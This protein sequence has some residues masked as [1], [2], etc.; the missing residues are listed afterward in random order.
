M[1]GVNCDCLADKHDYRDGSVKG[2][3]LIDRQFNQDR[4]KEIVLD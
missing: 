2:S 4:L 1:I 3:V